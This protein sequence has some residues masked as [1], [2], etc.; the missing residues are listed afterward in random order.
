MRRLVHAIRSQ[1]AYAAILS[2]RDLVR[3]EAPIVR[4][5]LADATVTRKYDKYLQT[6]ERPEPGRHFT[7]HNY[8]EKLRPALEAARAR[9]DQ[10][11]FDPACG[12]AFE[13]LLFALQGVTVAASDC[14]PE[15]CAIASVRNDLYRELLDGSFRMTV[16]LGNAIRTSTRERYDTV[17][18]QEAISH[19]HPA[20]EFLVAVRERYL[21]AGGSLIVCDSNSWNPVT[22]LRITK[23]LWAE[24]RT[25][26]HFVSD[27]VDPSTGQRTSIAEERLFSPV[28]MRRMLRAAGLVPEFTWMSGFA[29]PFMVRTR[30]GRMG[31]CIDSAG[32]AVPLFRV[33][34]GFYTVIARNSA[35]RG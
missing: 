32:R 13:A 10:T 7:D 6:Y 3:L 11:L 24:R 27:I 25:I 34:G 5:R 1:P 9:R 2:Y 15:R 20:E 26:R 8:A 31:R 29:L 28:T 18:V 30:D 22:R 12:N 4:A 33:V 21:K 17:F 14:A 16:S 23:H 19:I 35:G